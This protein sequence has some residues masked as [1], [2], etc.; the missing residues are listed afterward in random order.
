MHDRSARRGSDYAD[1]F[2]V[3]SPIDRVN[4][5][6]AT[7]EVIHAMTGIPMEKCRS[8]VEERKSLSEKP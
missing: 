6:T 1:V 8:F 3:D 4:L 2:T 5:R 7:A